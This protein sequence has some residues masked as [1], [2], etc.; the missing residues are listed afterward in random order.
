MDNIQQRPGARFCVGILI[1]RKARCD[2]EKRKR[3]DIPRLRMLLFKDATDIV[4]KIGGGKVYDLLFGFQGRSKRRGN[5]EGS[6]RI[7]TPK[8]SAAFANLCF[9]FLPKSFYKTPKRALCITFSKPRSLF[10]RGNLFFP[11]PS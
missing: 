10:L 7:A 8:R 11:R 6:F 4:I 1:Q 2:E 3:K 9:F 5:C